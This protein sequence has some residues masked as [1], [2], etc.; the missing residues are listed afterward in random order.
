MIPG[1]GRQVIGVARTCNLILI[2]LDAQKPMTH[3]RIIEVRSTLVS[4][5][6]HINVCVLCVQKELEGFGI[7]LNQE[8]PNIIFKQKDKGGVN[9]MTSVHDAHTH[10]LTLSHTHSLTR[11]LPLIGCPFD[12]FGYKNR[13]F[14]SQG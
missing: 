10:T 12:P 3:K 6:P 9:I 7:R 14:H 5:V 4:D 2:V 1:R 11:L 13:Y 8:P